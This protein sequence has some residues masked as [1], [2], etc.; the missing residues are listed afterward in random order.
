MVSLSELQDY[1]AICAIFALLAA[2]TYVI[3]RKVSFRIYNTRII[4]CDKIFLLIF[5]FTL[6]ILTAFR[7][8]SIGNDT[9]QYYYSYCSVSRYGIK[10]EARM[11]IGYRLLMYLFCKLFDSND[12]GF[13]ALLITSSIFNYHCV[14]HFI[15]KRSCNYL[16]SCFVFF[17]LFY[18]IFCSVI[19]Q[20]ISISIIL[21][22]LDKLEIKKTKAFAIYVA[23]AASFHISAIIA[24]VY[25]YFYRFRVI[26]WG[27]IIVLL[28]V[29][30][31]VS[32]AHVIR[33]VG[34]M[35]GVS[36]K[37]IATSDNSLAVI[38]SIIIYSLFLL[39]TFIRKN[40]NPE[41]Q[42]QHQF[43]T[44]CIV[45][46]IIIDI[47]SFG[48]AIISR[49]TLYFTIM[50]VIYVPQKIDEI[51]DYRSKALIHTASMF[52]LFL[53]NTAILVFRPEWNHIWPYEIMEKLW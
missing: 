23:I 36:A 49:F 53:Y 33:S 30:S 38:I 1:F 52:G 22:G 45:M 46:V 28:I 40:K 31:L 27:R 5:I 11:E 51:A 42:S 9:M 18:G 26:K 21:L 10:G 14:Y 4:H 32:Y 15:S 16:L 41:F 47:L 24:L 20:A 43:E 13:R 17:F 44:Y 34:E 12:V 19:R 7:S 6:F 8:Y 39:L 25:I 3:G 29:S 2:V 48:T 37:Y 50:L 35:I